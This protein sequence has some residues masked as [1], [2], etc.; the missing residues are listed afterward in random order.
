MIV[1]RNEHDGWLT[2]ARDRVTFGDCPATNPSRP[3]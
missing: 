2:C 3:G 1:T